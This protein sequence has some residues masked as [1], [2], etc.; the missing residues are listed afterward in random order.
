ML[1][2]L[3]R[4]VSLTLDACELTC[5]PRQ[6][7]D[8]QL[9]HQ[10]HRTY[11]QA[12]EDLGLHVISLPPQPDMPDAVFV[13]D[14]LLVLDELAIVSRMGAASRRA[15]SQTLAQTIAEYRPLRR[16]TDPA[17]LEGGDVIRVGRE[18]FVGLSKRTNQAGI[19]QLRHWVEPLGYRVHPV[20]VH[21]CLH[22]KSACCY[23]GAGKM[24]VNPDWVD[25]DAF[26]DFKLIPVATTEP[27]AANVLRIHNTVLMPACFPQTALVLQNEGLH[28]RT[29]D[30]SELMKAEAAITCSSVIFRIFTWHAREPGRLPAEET[31]K[32]PAALQ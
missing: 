22:L 2:A 10:Q 5:V 28:L 23:T 9:A 20:A 14:P 19:G 27:G 3:T 30:I 4:G 29:L 16:L 6:P 7:I 26:H 18:L 31:A 12:L 21:G 17:T 13:E 24:L 8:V 11:E 1:A 32:L 15:E 25:V